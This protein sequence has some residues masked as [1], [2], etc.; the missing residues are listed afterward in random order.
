[1][2][3]THAMLSLEPLG[4]NLPAGHSTVVEELAQWYPALQRLG[5]MDPGAQYS[6]SPHL[7]YSF[8][9]LSSGH[10]SPPSCVPAK[11]MRPSA[12]GE[13]S[14]GVAHNSP[15]GHTFAMIVPGL[16]TSVA[17]QYCP[18][19]QGE[20]VPEQGL[21]TFKPVA[22]HSSPMEQRLEHAVSEAVE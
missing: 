8:G 19:L 17:G 21:S 1:M 18:A 20:Q 4:Q 7:W 2:S 14:R 15:G 22:M 11:H 9:G 6:L 16:P 5:S 13:R 3:V 10:C 12:H